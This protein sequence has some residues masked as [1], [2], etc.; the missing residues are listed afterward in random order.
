M[1]WETMSDYNGVRMDSVFGRFAGLSGMLDILHG[2][3]MRLLGLGYHTPFIVRRMSSLDFRITKCFLMFKNNYFP[4]H[5]V[6]NI[7][8]KG[9]GTNGYGP[10]FRRVIAPKGHYSE[11]SL[12]RRV[13]APKG[14]CSE[15]LLL[16][17]V[18][19]PK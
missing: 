4:A 16:R 10:L 11:G 6:L 9:H 2:M 19:A 12:F 13:I 1:D 15:G 5:A 7:L 3:G 17:R 18:I 14:H 8:S